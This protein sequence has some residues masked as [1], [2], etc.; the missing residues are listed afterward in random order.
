LGGFRDGLGSR[1]QAG[2]YLTALSGAR[3][4]TGQS[5]RGVFAYA[6]FPLESSSAQATPFPLVPF[7]LFG[8]KL[9]H[10]CTQIMHCKQF[11]RR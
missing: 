10:A 11:E 3:A 6:F 4:V 9:K 2:A 1:K 5:S 7:Q 8:Q